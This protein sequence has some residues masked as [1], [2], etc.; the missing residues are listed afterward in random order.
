MQFQGECASPESIGIGSID[1]VFHQRDEWTDND[2]DSFFQSS[3]QLIAER[4][5]SAGWHY[6]KGIAVIE[7][8]LYNFLLM[9]SERAEA[10]DFEKGV[11]YG[12]IVSFSRQHSAGTP[13]QK[14]TR[15]FG[16]VP[17]K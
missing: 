16:G 6:G 12:S 7:N 2:A 9:R 8:C 15:S 10:E 14:P 5:S 17:V 4:L 3:R 1:L 13:A 11:V